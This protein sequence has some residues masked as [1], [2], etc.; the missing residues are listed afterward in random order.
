MGTRNFGS[1]CIVPR[2]LD[3]APDG[4]PHLKL[5]ARGKSVDQPAARV[6]YRIFVGHLTT[7]QAVSHRCGNDACLNPGHLYARSTSEALADC[8]RRVL[9]AEDIWYIRRSTLS[10]RQLSEKLN[11][12]RSG[13]S[14][15]RNGK[16]GVSERFSFRYA[17]L[18]ARE[19]LG[20]ILRRQS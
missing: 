18:I 17:L 14:D 6:V 19:H 13:I 7:G 5:A 10:G 12:S 2:H 3:M 1:A 8:R 20:H 15:I 16:K 9:F 4:R 11:Y